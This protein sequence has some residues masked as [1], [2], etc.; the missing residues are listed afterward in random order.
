LIAKALESAG[1][2]STSS[3]SFDISENVRFQSSAKGPVV[4]S[5]G[6]VPTFFYI[7]AAWSVIRGNRAPT[8]KMLVGN[9]T[10][11]GAL[12][13]FKTPFECL[14]FRFRVFCRHQQLDRDLSTLQ[15]LEK[16][17]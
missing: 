9:S 13:N 1:V 2:M 16:L 11:P 12:D 8:L 7:R 17:G 14:C 4:V 6:R 10:Y 15:R 5:L 3:T